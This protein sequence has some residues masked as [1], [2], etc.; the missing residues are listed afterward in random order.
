MVTDKIKDKETK[1][2]CSARKIRIIKERP[3]PKYL[4]KTVLPVGLEIFFLMKTLVC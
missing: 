4:K 2:W 1:S 3:F